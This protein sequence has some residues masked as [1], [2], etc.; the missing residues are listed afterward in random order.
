MVVF[1]D[2][3]ELI[4]VEQLTL[5]EAR[6]VL[7]RAEA[8]LLFAYNAGHAQSLRSEIAALADQVQ[9]LET[10]ARQVAVEDAAVEH[11]IDLWEDRGLVV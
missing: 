2:D 10:E 3:D 5:D 8:E 11:D 4:D 7:A 1:V 6:L 9:W